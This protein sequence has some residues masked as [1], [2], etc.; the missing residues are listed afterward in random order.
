MK[1]ILLMISWILTSCQP[2]NVI[3]VCFFDVGSEF[4]TTKTP[5][6]M[7]QLASNLE[8]EYRAITQQQYDSIV[9]DFSNAKKAK[10]P[11]EQECRFYINIEGKKYFTDFWFGVFDE[12]YYYLNVPPKT[13][14]LLRRLAGYY[15]RIWHEEL[16]YVY[17]IEKYGVPSDYI[18]EEP[19]MSPGKLVYLKVLKPGESL[20]QNPKYKKGKS[21]RERFMEV[22]K[23]SNL[24]ETE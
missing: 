22:M 15:N 24:N 20:V 12:K 9:S 19:D 6:D 1:K 10:H 21:F 17:D 4:S 16:Q 14:Y 3:K 2:E 23:N 11:R 13:V 8:F 7:L 18:Y 5:D